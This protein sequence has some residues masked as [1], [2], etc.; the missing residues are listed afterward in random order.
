LATPDLGELRVLL[1][2]DTEGK[3]HSSRVT[4]ETDSL[5]AMV[6]LGN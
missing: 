2:E 3:G 1:V 5:A 4:S 6:R